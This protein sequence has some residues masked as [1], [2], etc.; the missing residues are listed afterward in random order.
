MATTKVGDDVDLLEEELI[1]L[2]VKS[3]VVNIPDKPS[4]ICTVWTKKS[5]NSNSLRAQMRC[6]WKTKKKFDI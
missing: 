6:I 2:S 4:L 1:H 5:Y 3:V